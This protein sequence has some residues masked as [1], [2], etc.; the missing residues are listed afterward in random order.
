[1]NNNIFKLTL[2]LILLLSTTLWAKN[3]NSGDWSTKPTLHLVPVDFMKES[4][5]IIAQ[6]VKIEYKDDVD[7]KLWI[8]RTFH[9]IIKVLDEKGIE[10][11]NKMTI[12]VIPGEEVLTLK[13]RTIL[14]DG[15]VLEVAKDKFKEV[16]DDNGNVKLAFALDGVAKNAELELFFA[17]KRTAVVF[18][19][20]IFQFEIP[21]VK[22]SFTLITPSRLKFEEKGYNGFP[23]VN[24]TLIDSTRYIKAIA[25]K[26]PALHTEEYSFREANLM[27]AEYKLSYTPEKAEHIRI[28]T[29][30]ELAEILY[31][32]VYKYSDKEKKAVDKFL[33]TAGINATDDEE[34]K[35]KKI[36]TA[37]KAG[38]NVNKDLSDEQSEKLD[39]I[40]SRKAASE[41]GLIRLFACCFVQSSVKHEFGM[42]TN[43]TLSRLDPE[44]EN[45]NNLDEYV[46][47]FPDRKKFMSPLAAYNRYPFTNQSVLNNKGLF[48]KLTT[49]GDITNAITDIRLIPPR[50]AAES[51]HDI[52]AVISF[53]NAMEA[54]ADINYSFTGYCAQGL[55]EAALLVPKDKLKDL[56][57]NV[58]AL[59]EK[60]ENI[61]D[62]SITG[63][64]FENYYSNTP[65]VFHA[66]MKVAQLVEKAGPK[67]ILRI[68]DVIGRQ[69]ELYQK[70]ERQMPIDMP[71]THCLNRNIVVNIPENYKLLN[72][73]TLIIKSEFKD[74]SGS[75]V[76]AFYSNYKLEGNKLT[77]TIQEVYNQLHVAAKDY[78]PF[79]RVI[80]ASADFNKVTLLLSK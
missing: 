7:N 35:I 27:R 49:L 33:V 78:E 1:M 58:I 79:R 16:K 44:F 55:R 38:F 2:S 77:V 12:E 72:P 73:E 67:Y 20:Q 63:E 34:A 13:A 4:A 8:Y 17:Y 26:V 3:D 53:T 21:V 70:E 28:N 62:Y 6:D 15:S 66:N 23:T 9:R 47:Y 80:N 11:F 31:T 56:T 52:N 39:Q 45:W 71:Y 74:E 41:N 40:I 43:I 37:I 24:D 5:V 22:E 57:Q 14:P 51:Q 46:F 36:E 59:T 65:L 29:W 42:T 25:E 18:G 48:C 32:S 60:T 54:T 50:P 75:I 61:V 10:E 76:A 30:Q 68:G 69:S 19:K 64:A